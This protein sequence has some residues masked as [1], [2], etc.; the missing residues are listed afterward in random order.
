LR[1]S[2]VVCHTGAAEFTV[3]LPETSEQTAQPPVERILGSVER[4]NKS[5]TLEYRL[6]VQIGL[7]Q[8]TDGSSGEEMMEE[9]L[10]RRRINQFMPTA[11]FTPPEPLQDLSGTEQRVPER[12]NHVVRSQ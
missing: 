7:S 10:R 6:Q 2:D 9:V 1:G 8:Y 12:S 11:I 5:S 4:W 3:I